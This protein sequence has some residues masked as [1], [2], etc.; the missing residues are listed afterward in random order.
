MN[1]KLLPMFP[2][3]LLFPVT[4]FSASLS[5]T[6]DRLGQEVM[7]IG[8]ALGVV[9]LAIG[10]VCLAMGKQDGNEKIYKAIFGLI[11]ILLAPAIVKLL[12]TLI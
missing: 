1:K 8:V 10:G 11:I 3:L 6:A 5:G 2:G 7:R 12:K 9:A 4:G